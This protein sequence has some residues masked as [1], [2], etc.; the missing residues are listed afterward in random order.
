MRKKHLVLKSLK[1][2]LY[3]EWM[4]SNPQVLI[5]LAHSK[6]EKISQAILSLI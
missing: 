4:K 2:V 3:L 5:K 1:E 6:K